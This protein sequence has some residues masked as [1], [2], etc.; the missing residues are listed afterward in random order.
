[1]V[2]INR[3]QKMKCHMMG[4][5]LMVSKETKT[6]IIKALSEMSPKVRNLIAEVSYAPTKINKV[7]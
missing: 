1:M 5:S 6:R 2:K 3:I 7:A 4:L